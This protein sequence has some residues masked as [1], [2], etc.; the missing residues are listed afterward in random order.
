MNSPHSPLNQ[1]LLGFFGF[2]FLA[3]LYCLSP[4]PKL[5]AYL[6]FLHLQNIADTRSFL[7]IP[8]F[9]NI[10]SSF[11]LSLVSLFWLLW[12]VNQKNNTD[13]VV[14]NSF[15]YFFYILFFTALLA[16]GVGFSIYHWTP[17]DSA[18]HIWGQLPAT[19][20]ILSFFVALLA[21]KIYQKFGYAYGLILF[22]LL[23]GCIASVSNTYAPQIQSIDPHPFVNLNYI[24]PALFYTLFT[25]SSPQQNLRLKYL[26]LSCLS[27]GI[28]PVMAIHDHLIYRLTKGMISGLSLKYLYLGMAAIYI[29]YYLRDKFHSHRHKKVYN[30][31]V[32]KTALANQN[33]P[34]AKRKVRYPL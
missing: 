34:S 6:G 28:A 16:A 21:P 1:F 29:G 5:W 12:L 8:S 13:K 9:L 19:I 33:V 23:F 26:F 10:F 31:R 2:L 17:L 15:E 14:L 3:I 25:L 4:G 11:L 7:G 18:S 24:L 22:F 30:P 32:V 27:L 20:A